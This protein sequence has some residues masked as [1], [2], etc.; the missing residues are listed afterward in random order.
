M[1]SK[2]QNVLYRDL[3][4]SYLLLIVKSVDLQSDAQK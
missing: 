1:H 3:L 2:V 4:P